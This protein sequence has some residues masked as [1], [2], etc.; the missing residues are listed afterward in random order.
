MS[1]TDQAAASTDTETGAEA[2]RQVLE[3]VTFHLGSDRLTRQSLAT[4][5]DVARRLRQQPDAE[6]EIAGYTDSVGDPAFNLDL[7][8]RRAQAVVRYLTRH[9][10]PAERLTAKGYGAKSP[11]APNTTREGRKKNRRVELHIH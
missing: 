1:T 9:G 4:L 8:L 11:I 5:N 7:S 10:V 6:V 3:G 2:S